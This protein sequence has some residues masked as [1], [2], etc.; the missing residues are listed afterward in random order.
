[1][2]VNGSSSCKYNVLL[3]ISPWTLAYRPHDQWIVELKLQQVETLGYARDG[4]G[5]LSS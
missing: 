3:L 1:M 2:V 5:G 4:N